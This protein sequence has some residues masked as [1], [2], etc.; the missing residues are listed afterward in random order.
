MDILQTMRDRLADEEADNAERL[1]AAIA[2]LE[3]DQGTTRTTGTD[4]GSP[5]TRRR[6]RRSRDA[7]R[8]VTSVVPLGTLIKWVDDHP[9]ETTTA[10]AKPTGGGQ[11]AILALLKESETAGDVRREGQRRATRWFVISDD[12]RVAARSAEHEGQSAARSGQARARRS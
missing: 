10:I 9:G 3:N 2:V 12:D 5:S 1:R 11:A 6:A 7:D 4:R 8:P